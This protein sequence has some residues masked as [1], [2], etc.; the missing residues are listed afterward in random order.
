MS[1]VELIE[2]QKKYIEGFG[3]LSISSLPNGRWKVSV[4]NKYYNVMAY[5]DFNLFSAI[6]SLVQKLKNNEAALGIFNK[7]KGE[8]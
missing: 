6:S 2:D 4:R 3:K 8:S 5:P 1:D 7:E